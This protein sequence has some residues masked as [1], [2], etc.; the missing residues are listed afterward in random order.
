MYNIH[1]VLKYIRDNVKHQI[2][3]TLVTF[4]SQ[5]NYKNKQLLFKSLLNILKLNEHKKKIKKS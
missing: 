2:I 3:G 5:C 4:S 1:Y